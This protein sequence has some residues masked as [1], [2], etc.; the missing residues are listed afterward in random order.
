MSE[1]EASTRPYLIRAIYEWCTDHGYTPYLAVRADASVQVPRPYVQDGQITLNVSTTATS[2]LKMGNEFIEFSARF[3]GVPQEIMVPVDR[4]MAIYARENGQGMA[5]AEAEVDDA[6]DD[7][8]ADD[9]ATD[10]APA[11]QLVPPAQGSRLDGDD[12]PPPKGPQGGKPGHGKLK[13]IK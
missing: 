1:S 6:E 5:F 2:G 9:E 10:V 4:V 3:G 8:L 13:R 12:E 11:I 7:D